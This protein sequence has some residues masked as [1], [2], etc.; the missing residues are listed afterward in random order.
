MLLLFSRLVFADECVVKSSE[1]EIVPGTPIT[2]EATS[3]CGTECVWTVLPDEYAEYYTTQ[4]SSE[5]QFLFPEEEECT[6]IVLR[7]SAECS[8]G[9]N[10]IDLQLTCQGKT[11][12]HISGGGCGTPQYEGS[13]YGIIAPFLLALGVRRRR[14]NSRS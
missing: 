7:F 3:D 4:D 10:D 8:D 5:A 14:K 2:F 12:V 6:A 11:D 9:D 13:N 1:T